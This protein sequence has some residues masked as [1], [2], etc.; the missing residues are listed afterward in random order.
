MEFRPEGCRGG[1]HGGGIGLCGGP[2]VFDT[3]EEG[4]E[5]FLGELPSLVGERVPERGEVGGGAEKSF[6]IADEPCLNA[7]ALL[8]VFEEGVKAGLFGG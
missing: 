6:W 2:E 7:N 1:V 3:R 5:F 8:K 4:G